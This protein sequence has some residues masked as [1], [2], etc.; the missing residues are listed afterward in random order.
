[1]SGVRS[2]PWRGTFRSLERERRLRMKY[3][4]TLT[5]P[6]TSRNSMYSPVDNR[7][8]ESQ[9]A[10]IWST[11]QTPISTNTAFT[12]NFT[13]LSKNCAISMVVSWGKP[14]HGLPAIED[15]THRGELTREGEK[16][17][18]LKRK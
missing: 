1:M 2:A 9:Q 5:A 4:I 13:V 11:R 7:I 3:A 14:F 10:T 12:R 6:S 8:L 18:G 17:C 15:D 16:N